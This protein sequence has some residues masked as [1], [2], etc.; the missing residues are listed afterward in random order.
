M[1]RTYMLVILVAACGSG[2]PK[3]WKDQPLETV[4]GTVDGHGYTI[5]LPKGCEKSKYSE[6]WQYH[7]KVNGEGYVFPPSVSL[8][9]HAKKQSLDEAIASDI[10]KGEPLHKEAQ[11]DGFSYTKRTDEKKR[12]TFAITQWKYAGDGALECRALL[13]DLHAN[14]DGVKAQ[15]P[16]V[17]K[18]CAS[19]KVK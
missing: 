16:L 7:A 12:P 11:A 18:M 10:D 1:L 3:H 19:L 2:D 5:D 17:E 6:E 15:I 9:W 14:E 4:S 8:Y 13:W